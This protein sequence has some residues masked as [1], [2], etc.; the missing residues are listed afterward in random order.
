MNIIK[1]TNTQNVYR[2]KIHIGIWLLVFMSYCAHSDNKFREVYEADLP[3]K[4][5]HISFFENGSI[6]EVTVSTWTDRV[7]TKNGKK[8][9]SYEQG[10][11]YEEK[12]GFIKVFNESG[13]LIEEK[14]DSA[15][16][17]GVSQ[18]ELLVAFKLFKANEVVKQH[19]A[20]TNLELIVFGGFNYSDDKACILGSRCVHVL[21]ATKEHMVLA[22]AIVRLTDQKVVYPNFDMTA[23]SLS[24]ERISKSIKNK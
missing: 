1:S 9:Y 12:K 6:K 7:N 14:R 21:A 18:E 19:F 23:S 11:N 15:I 8:Y 16:D 5:M 20:S 3:R 22:H 2:I 17:G 24:E 10:F 13:K 4:A